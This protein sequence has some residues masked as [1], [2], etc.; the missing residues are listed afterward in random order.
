MQFAVWSVVA[1]PL[2]MTNDLAT[3]D[4][5]SKAILQNTEVIA[6]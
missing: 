2:L 3:V 6:V 5:E 1:A 4:P